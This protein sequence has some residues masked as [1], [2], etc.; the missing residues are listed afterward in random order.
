[1]RK[2]NLLVTKC[3][4]FISQLPLVGLYERM[5]RAL[6]ETILLSPDETDLPLESYVYNLIH[7]VPLPPP[8]TSLKLHITGKDITCQRPGIINYNIYI[9]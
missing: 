2:D 5:L 3:I 7:E 6:L 9:I 1:M 4:G 8:G